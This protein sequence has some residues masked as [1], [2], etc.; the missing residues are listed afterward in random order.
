MSQKLAAAISR[1]PIPL[2]GPGLAS[3]RSLRPMPAVVVDAP[4]RTLVGL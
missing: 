4:Q 1:K 3:W 2:R